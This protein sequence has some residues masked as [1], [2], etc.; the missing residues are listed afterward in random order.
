MPEPFR[1]LKGELCCERVPL[2]ALAEKHGTPL[3]V[4]SATEIAERVRLFAAAF[5][6]VPHTIG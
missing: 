5:K 4:Y 1:Y 3:Y 2:S 6:G